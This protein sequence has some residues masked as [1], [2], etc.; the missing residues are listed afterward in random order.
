MGRTPASTPVHWARS[1]GIATRTIA[2]AVTAAIVP[3]R[4]RTVAVIRAQRVWVGFGTPARG[5]SLVPIRA[6]SAGRMSSATEAATRAT[7]APPMP[8]DLRNCCGKTTS[9]SMAAA[10]VSALNT[11]VRPAV[12]IATLI[13]SCTSRSAPSSSRKRDTRNSA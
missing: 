4:R 9:E 6:N 8:I 3:G 7:T 1:V 5:I 10:T 11:T 13:A 2:T 12:D